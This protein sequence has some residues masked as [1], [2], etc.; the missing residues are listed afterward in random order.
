[1]EAAKPQAAERRSLLLRPLPE[2]PVNFLV[3]RRAT[4]GELDLLVVLG[5]H[6]SGAVAER[7]TDALAVEAAVLLQLPHEIR[8]R[9]RG[10][11]DAHE[12]DTA[13]AHVGGAGV[14]QKL[15]QV[16]VTAADHR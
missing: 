16:T 10:A 13:V 15:L 8:L 1:M 14:R 12:G 2:R 3:K 9:E 5:A 6:Q 4:R 11:A 7:A